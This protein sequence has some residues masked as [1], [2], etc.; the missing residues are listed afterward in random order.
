MINFAFKTNINTLGINNKRAYVAIPYTGLEGL[1]CKIS[2]CV[3]AALVSKLGCICYAPIS[4]FH[5]IAEQYSLPGN[6]DYW[7]RTNEEF[8]TWCDVLVIIVPID[9]KKT[10]LAI[11]GDRLVDSSK[12]VQYE[13]HLAKQLKKE[14]VHVYID[15]TEI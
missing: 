10:M 8:V 15:F 9:R 14:I 13:Y 6:F 7:K 11:D 2:D 4:M 12:G 3:T 5:N 1:S